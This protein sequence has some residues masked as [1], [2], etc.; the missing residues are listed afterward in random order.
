[1]AISDICGGPRLP[2]GELRGGNGVPY[3]VL[4]NGMLDEYSV[5]HRSYWMKRGYWLW[6][7]RGVLAG[8][9]GLHCLNR[10]EIRRAVDWIGRLPK[11]VVGNGVSGTE[12]ASLPE[13]GRF[14]Q[15]ASQRLETAHWHSSF[16]GYIRRRDWTGSYLHGRSCQ[17]DP[18]IALGHCRN[19]RT[20]L[21]HESGSTH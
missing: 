3:V 18:G 15:W 17:S 1:M 19:R 11:F 20:G 16:R 5:K 6:R 10:A 14:A 21:R 2:A 7:E 9:R 12:L 4:L 13:R 8:S